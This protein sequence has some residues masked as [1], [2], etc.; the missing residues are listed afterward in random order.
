MSPATQ[1]GS[2]PESYAPIGLLVLLVMFIAVAIMVVSHPRLTSLVVRRA[3]SFS[4]IDS[5]GSLV[6]IV[7]LE[8]EF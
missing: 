6:I 4:R 8:C 5:V 7:T 3:L 1:L 2:V